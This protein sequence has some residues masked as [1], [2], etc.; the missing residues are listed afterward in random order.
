MK[1]DILEVLDLQQFRG[2]AMLAVFSL[3]GPWEYIIV[4]VVVMIFFGAGKLP[5]VL[6]QMGRGVKAFKNGMNEKDLD[7]LSKDETDTDVVSSGSPK[8]TIKD[9]Q[10]V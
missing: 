1:S 3:G 10:E 7:L 5:Q 4:L 2:E 8:E 9:V 6:G